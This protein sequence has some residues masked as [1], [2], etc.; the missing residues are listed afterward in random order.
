[1]AK[2]KYTGAGAMV[3]VDVAD[4][5]IFVDVGCTT[6]MTPPPQ[7]L[8]DIDVTCQQDASADSEPGIEQLSQSSFVEPYDYVATQTLI[9]DF[10]DSRAVKDWKY[11]FTK[12][13]DSQVIAF[14]GYVSG[15]VPNS[16]G[17]NDPLTRTV[18]ITR[19]SGVTYNPV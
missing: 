6:S 9:D 13:T 8:T 10:Y 14:S 5:G 7:V 15:L 4:D 19:T 11:T 12:G 18:T 1:M 3:S 16:A 17:G 2:V